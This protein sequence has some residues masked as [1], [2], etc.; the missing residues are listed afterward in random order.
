M[1][2]L[3]PLAR[4]WIGTPFQHRAALR[5]V[6]C[7]CL[8]LVLGVWREAGLSA[9]PPPAYAPD[10]EGP[11]LARAVTARLTPREGA[12]QPGDLLLFGLRAGVPARH[13]GLLSHAGD[14]P[15]FIHAYSGHGVVESH[16][17]A[18]WARRLRGVFAPP[19][20]RLSW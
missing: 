3:V 16:L 15:R 12:P 14:A 4:D 5:G 19:T 17:T 18:P 20:A 7:D 1:S 10:W 8:G 6:G 11:A 13:L 9:P 2:A